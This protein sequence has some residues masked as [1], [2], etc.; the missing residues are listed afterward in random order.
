MGLCVEGGDE[1]TDQLFAVYMIDARLLKIL[2]LEAQIFDR[3]QGRMSAAQ[4]IVARVLEIAINAH[5]RGGC[6]SGQL[7]EV[8]ASIAR[9]EEMAS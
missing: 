5:K 9:L 6:T 4:P 1:M 7:Q 2:A 3:K 8:E